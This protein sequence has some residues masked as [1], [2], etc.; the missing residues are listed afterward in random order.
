MIKRV[1]ENISFA[2]VPGAAT[3]QIAP[4]VNNTSGGFVVPRCPPEA[5]S[6]DHLLSLLLQSNP[7]AGS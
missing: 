7:L 1:A 3:K 2:I 4:L 5:F 6:D